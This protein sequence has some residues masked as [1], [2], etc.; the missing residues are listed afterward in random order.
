[1]AITMGL[2]GPG[3]LEKSQPASKTVTA[4]SRG[5]VS[6]DQGAGHRQGA[7]AQARPMMEAVAMSS[8]KRARAT[9][10]EMA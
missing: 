1:V 5:C 9:S 3:L 10:P 2:R 8:C 6:K 7:E 4:D